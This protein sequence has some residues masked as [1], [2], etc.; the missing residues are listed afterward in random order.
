MSLLDLFLP[1]P[2]PSPPSLT[3]HLSLAKAGLFKHLP[4][5]TTCPETGLA[6]LD[7]LFLPALRLAP[8]QRAE[9]APFDAES[10]SFF[11]PVTILFRYLG[12]AYKFPVE[13]ETF[14]LAPRPHESQLH[15]TPTGIASIALPVGLVCLA[16]LLAHHLSKTSAPSFNMAELF[17]FIDETLDW[18]SHYVNRIETLQ[19]ME[20]AASNDQELLAQIASVK[21]QYMDHLAALVAATE[22]V[23]KT[24]TSHRAADTPRS[25][26]NDAA[27]CTG[28]GSDADADQSSTRAP[29][30]SES[31][32]FSATEEV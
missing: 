32:Y 8:Q 22:M 12:V 17:P 25:A 5:D 28:T 3:T 29:S 30:E 16:R 1:T 20:V 6:L 10:A 9:S 21:K 31:E 14:A 19:A 11:L 27:F 26:S 13:R 15:H 2:Q 23:L 7:R 4:T 18:C 24:Y